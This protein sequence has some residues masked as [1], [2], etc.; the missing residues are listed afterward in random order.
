MSE[1]LLVPDTDLGEEDAKAH[2]SGKSTGPSTVGTGP[3]GVGPSPPAPGVSPDPSFVGRVSEMPFVNGALGRLHRAY[4]MGRS[5]SS[6]IRLGGDTIE[7][8]ARCLGGVLSPP[9]RQLDSYAGRLVERVTETSCAA[10]INVV[11]DSTPRSHME[12]VLQT[13]RN[14]ESY[15]N[16]LLGSLR[17]AASQVQ[18]RLDGGLESCLEAVR[19]QETSL[20]RKAE[21]K[22][23]ALRSNEEVVHT[24]RSVVEL[25]NGTGSLLPIP[26]QTMM[27]SL[28]LGLPERFAGALGTGEIHAKAMLMINEAII[29]VKSISN[30][31]A[32]YVGEAAGMEEVLST[33]SG[34][35]AAET[36]LDLEN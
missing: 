12:N 20:Q 1:E 26:G 6:L 32:S 9:L 27:K 24:L 18:V 30:I 8:S 2:G 29:M 34:A 15:L 19:S 4:T 25:V 28:L 23:A 5:A 16:H 31:I 10:P 11:I 33:R 17:E 22:A 7:H 35:V 21:A 3:A 14:A 36:L 13:L